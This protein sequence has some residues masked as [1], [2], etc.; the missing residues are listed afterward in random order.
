VYRRIPVLT[1]GRDVYN[2]TRIILSKLETLFPDY[3][4]LSSSAPDQKAIE[5]LLEYWTVDAGIF[6]RCA[7]L[8]PSDAPLAIDPTF[9]KDR[10]DFSGRAW[11]KKAADEAR[12]EALVEMKSAFEVG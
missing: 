12:P 7:Q 8:I 4:P 1:I 11:S 10:E 6:V 5:K 2:D 3:P 9:R